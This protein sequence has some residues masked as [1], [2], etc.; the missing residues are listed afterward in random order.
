MLTTIAAFFDESGKLKSHGVVSIGCV[1]GYVERFNTSFGEEWEALL[2]YYGIQ[3]LSG[4]K[5]LNHHIPLSTKRPCL[6][7]QERTEALLRFIRCMRK[8]VQLITGLATDA[9]IF[10]TLPS[11][12]F[13]VYGHDPIFM[14]FVRTAMHVTE[15]T[16]DRSKIT[17][18]C[19][20]DEETALHFYR[21][22]R[23]VKKV[24]PDARRKFGGIAFVDD[25][26]LFGVQASDLVASIVRYQGAFQLNGEAYD[27]QP[28]YEALIAHPEKHESFLFNIAIGIGDRKKMSEM[29]EQMKDDY[30]RAVTEEKEKQQRIREFRSHHAQSNERE[31]RRNKSGTGGG[32]SSKK[33]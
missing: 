6:G 18:I 3:T 14:T 4:K 1:A 8:H 29:A 30:E 26:Y 23:R 27:Y 24:W 28:L 15:F 17:M 16:P 10:K 22:Y 12:F 9:K 31:S 20:D 21:L 13:E 19:D 7:V 11:H 2:N 25:R 5:V 32:K 33:K